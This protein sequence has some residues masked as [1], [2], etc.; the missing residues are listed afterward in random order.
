[1]KALLELTLANIGLWVCLY[2]SVCM[3][4]S[5]RAYVHTESRYKMYSSLCVSHGESG[6]KMLEEYLA[7]PGDLT[8]I[9]F[10]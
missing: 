8:V 7:A 3:R 2:T 4:V 9:F 1:M 5:M 6:K 10:Y